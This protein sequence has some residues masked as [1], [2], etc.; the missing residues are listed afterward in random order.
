MFSFYNNKASVPFR[1]FEKK[2]GFSDIDFEIIYEGNKIKLGDFWYFIE[3]SSLLFVPK[4]FKKEDNHI[5]IDFDSYCFILG[6]SNI[7]EFNVHYSNGHML[8]TYI[9]SKSESIVSI[10]YYFNEGRDFTQT[11]K[12]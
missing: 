6:N 8:V 2:H 3:E 9:S 1:K 11:Y 10:S 7:Y 5:F 12:F 4:V